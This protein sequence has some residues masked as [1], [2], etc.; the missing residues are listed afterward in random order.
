MLRLFYRLLAKYLLNCSSILCSWDLL[1][2]FSSISI[3]MSDIILAC[4]NTLL[5]ALKF[6]SCLMAASLKLAHSNLVLHCNLPSRSMLVLTFL[7][8]QSFTK[9]HKH[10][11]DIHM[12]L[13]IIGSLKIIDLISQ[14]TSFVLLRRYWGY[15]LVVMPALTHTPQLLFYPGAAV[16]GPQLFF[17]ISLES[18]SV[19]K[20]PCNSNTNQLLSL[21]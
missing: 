7:T 5:C 9:F 10:M 18:L 3:L 13:Q 14:D 12:L 16:N 15:L 20:P 17:H 6:I 21:S 4:Q 2:V 1:T 11:K 8:H 19:L